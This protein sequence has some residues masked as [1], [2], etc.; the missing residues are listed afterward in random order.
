MEDRLKFSLCLGGAIFCI[1]LAGVAIQKF[2]GRW[3][4]R[5]PTVVAGP[6]LTFQATEA[7]I[8][9][10]NSN[11]RSSSKRF[12][13]ITGAVINPG[14]YPLT[15][16]MRVADLVAAAGGLRYD[17]ETAK[18]NLAAPV[19]D[20]LHIHV[21]TASFSQNSKG[22]ASASASR[23]RAHE[24]KSANKELHYV[25]VNTADA[26]ELSSLPGIGPKL[27]ERIVEHRRQYGVFKNPESLLKVPGI[28]RAKLDRF[29]A[30]LRF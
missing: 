11:N 3:E 18:L 7:A 10:G 4:D 14:M 22:S 5:G 24:K 21:E 1:G 2:S 27:G 17:A 15:E 28:G 26:E 8:H 9:N 6:A 12:A 23:S 20:G 30:F 19:R 25:Y 16:E 29:R 13:Y